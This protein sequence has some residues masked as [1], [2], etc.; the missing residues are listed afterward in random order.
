M[1]AITHDEGRVIFNRRAPRRSDVN[2]VPQMNAEMGKETMAFNNSDEL[3]SVVLEVLGQAIGGTL[4]KVLKTHESPALAAEETPLDLHH[5]ALAAF[6]VF[7][8]AIKAKFSSHSAP[9]EEHIQRKYS[10]QFSGQNTSTPHH[11]LS[12]FFL[13]TF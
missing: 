11:Q 5:H 12:S 13:S 8:T 4:L 2:N 9:L 7:T 1:E 10:D 6:R 3:Q